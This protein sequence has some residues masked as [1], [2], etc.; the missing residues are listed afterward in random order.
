MTTHSPEDGGDADAGSPDTSA[1][2]HATILV[3]DDDRLVLATLVQ[4]LQSAGFDVL[5]AD[6]G[7]DAILLAR[8]RRPDLALLDMRMDGKTGMEV[9]A[10]LRDHIGTPFMFLSAFNDER[11]VRQAV[12]FGALAYLVKPLDVRQIVPAV[13]AALARARDRLPA[14]PTRPDENA[15][16]TNL[17]ATL[18]RGIAIGVLMERHRLSAADAALRLA[19]I[20]IEQRHS[21]DVVAEA[22]IGAAGMLNAPGGP[23]A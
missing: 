8:E 18:N 9:A 12:D 7:D 11:I 13:E 16:A 17:V 4:G 10:Y 14:P 21:E 15:P 5:E 20:A 3:C 22:L 6:N 19:A 23:T 2:R 1:A